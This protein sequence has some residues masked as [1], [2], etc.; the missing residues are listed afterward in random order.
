MADSQI[1]L[2]I[3]KN[4]TNYHANVGE[5]YIIEQNGKCQISEYNGTE[6][7]NISPNLIPKYIFVSDIMKT[8]ILFGGKL[9]NQK[10]WFICSVC[11]KLTLQKMKHLK[12]MTE[13]CVHCFFRM[14]HDNPNRK[15]YDGCPLTV[16]KYIHTYAGQHRSDKCRDPSKCFLCDYNNGKLLLDI[17]DRD[18]IYSGKLVDLLK[19]SSVDITI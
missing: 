4:T 13:M 15:E 5:R 9:W 3:V 1:V 2:S 8:V 16:G 18:I 17:N 10:K 6:W 19:A 12:G 14:H 7:K 11:E